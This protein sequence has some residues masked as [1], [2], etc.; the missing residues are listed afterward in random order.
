MT[1][2]RISNLLNVLKEDVSNGWMIEDHQYLLAFVLLLLF[3][4]GLKLLPAI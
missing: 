4:L 2:W 1:N 3:K